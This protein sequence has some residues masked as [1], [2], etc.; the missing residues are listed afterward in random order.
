MWLR[1]GKGFPDCLVV[2]NLS[3]KAGELG[4]IS[5]WER[6][7]GEG[8]GN[9]LQYSCVENPHGQRSLSGYSPRGTKE[10][11]TTER[12]KEQQGVEWINSKGELK[13]RNS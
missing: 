12:L 3:A 9:R 10:L 4:S 6:S 13:F 11:D 5:E 2:K 1:S 7:P 8:H